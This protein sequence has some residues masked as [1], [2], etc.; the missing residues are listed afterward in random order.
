M[1]DTMFST[2]INIEKIKK[3]LTENK[4]ELFII[5]LALFIFSVNILEFPIHVEFALQGYIGQEIIRGRPIFSTAVFAYPP[6]VYFI[7][8]FWMKLFFFLP[9][10]LA[11]RMGG[12][13]LGSITALLFY[14]VLKNFTKNDLIPIF[15]VLIFLSFTILI[16]YFLN[17]SVKT[18]LIFFIFLI[19]LSLFKKKY[20]FSG[21]STSLCFMT[22]QV[23]GLFLFG[24]ISYYFLNKEKIKNYVKFFI[25]FAIPLM[26]IVLYFLSYNLLDKFIDYVFLFALKFKEEINWMRNTVF[27]YISGWVAFCNTELLFLLFGLITGLI[28]L[29][30]LIFKIFK[31]KTISKNAK[32]KELFS[33]VLPFFLLFL[34][35]F[36]DFQAG[37][38]VVPLIPMISLGS[39]FILSRIRKKIQVVIVLLFIILYGYFPLFQPIY[40]PNPLLI[41]AKSANSLEDL[42]G[43]TKKYTYTEII[44]YSFF[45]RLGSEMTL[46]DQLKIAKYVDENM[47]ETDTIFSLNGADI[48][49][50]T[51]KENIVKY[52]ILSSNVFRIYAREEGIVEELKNNITKSFPKFIIAWNVGTAE[53]G[54]KFL[55]IEEFILKNYEKINLH[56]KY[57]I[58]RRI[59]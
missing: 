34:Y 46:Q 40:P 5:L 6:M 11:M 59:K 53:K 41:D 15:S 24:P 14:K 29:F 21:I 7:N 58:W 25:G 17:T 57:I 51:G 43:I 23:G 16:E 49:F 2:V 55:G 20:L 27:F 19:F 39:A 9:N 50:L 42:I 28:F 3:K 1:N 37:E 8:A 13:I 12:V 52:F 33:F 47:N 45:H 32:N 4:I 26:L 54:I 38:D 36:I 10:Y 44:Y 22:W 35:T 56:P 30:K 18:V 31:N 48:I